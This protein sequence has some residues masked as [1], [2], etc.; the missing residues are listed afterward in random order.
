[1]ESLKPYAYE[2]LPK[3][4][5]SFRATPPPFE[6]LSYVWGDPTI[7]APVF[8]DGR[9]LKV[10]INL[11]DA[12]KQ[13][14][15]RD[16]PRF[17]WVD[18]ICIDQEGN[19][20]EKSY[21]VNNMRKIYSNAT[22][23]IVWLGLDDNGLAKTAAD[24]MEGI[25]R[26]ICDAKSRSVSD[27]WE[28]DHLKILAMGSVSWKELSCNTPE[29]WNSLFWYFDR[30]WF[31]RV[32]VYQEVTSGPKVLF[33]CGEVELDWDIIGLI[34][35][36]ITVNRSLF[37][38]Y[39]FWKSNIW[40]A[41][42]YR[43]RRLL[44]DSCLDL[45]NSAR[46]LKATKLMDKVYSLL[47]MPNFSVRNLGLKA[48]YKKSDAEVYQDMG[49]V[50][51]TSMQNLDLLA[52]VQ[53]DQEISQDYPS[54]I[55]RWDQAKIR[56]PIQRE[57]R[58]QGAHNASQGLNFTCLRNSTDTILEV[59]GIQFDII[60]METSIDSEAWFN[61]DRQR[62]NPHPVHEFWHEQNNSFYPTGERSID[63]YPEVL[64]TGF[65]KQA[66]F[67]AYVLQLMKSSQ[68]LVRDHTS[69]HKYISLY[70]QGK[71]GNW[72]SWASVARVTTWGH[73]F[74]ITTKG[75][76]GLGSQAIKADDMVVILAGGEVPFIL[77]RDGEFFQLVGE[78][79][80]Y[81]IMNGEAV[82]NLAKRETFR[83]R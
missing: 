21:Q 59:S 77:R 9:M 56:H 80:V 71:S 13:L 38:T 63:V 23:V 5:S 34:A 82:H 20:E 65:G 4:E 24:A 53:H 55:P 73:S 3:E 69:I 51:L 68:H 64:T 41:V 22:G 36:Y 48:D 37:D 10:T 46:G 62:L 12:L 49:D 44:S 31:T 76:M 58:F 57:L 19:L 30:P 66:D 25:A 27:L 52:Y 11:R 29:T 50:A 32:W 61:K 14:R 6:A 1:M 15:Q 17:L 83:I 35:E 40:C 78:C 33:L 43:D 26:S 2:P 79:Y 39:C 16:N 47:G 70:K 74:F 18:A 45:L 42:T 28:I 67:S 60:R 72:E 7:R 81:G 75:Y 8:C 54:W